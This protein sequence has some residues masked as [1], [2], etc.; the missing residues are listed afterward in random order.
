MVQQG[1]L[2]LPSPPALALYA[3]T[4]L[5]E[6]PVLF[7]RI[8]IA[9]AV[10]AIVLLA[11][12]HPAAGA[13][14]LSRLA[15]IPTVWSIIALLTP[16]G[17]GWWWRQNMGG[18]HPS[19]REQTAYTDAVQTLQAAAALPLRIPSGWFVIDTPQPTPP[20]AARR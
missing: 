15:V 11:K 1:S 18:R 16:I 20:S 12:G 6:I 7:M 2:R 10:A 14:G 4:V 9:T 3:A 8:A 19:T 17:G 5:A 13:E